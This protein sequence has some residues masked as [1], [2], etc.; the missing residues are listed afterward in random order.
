SQT[1]R[2]TIPVGSLPG[3]VA[4]DPDGQR[5]YV[6]NAD[7]ATVSIVDVLSDAV[8]ATVPVGM[9]PSALAVEPASGRVWV[10][11]ADDHTVTVFVGATPRAIALDAAGPFAYVTNFDDDSVMVI[12]TSVIG[13]AANAVV[14]TIPVPDGPLGVDVTPDGRQVWV[15]RVF[16]GSVS[17]IDTAL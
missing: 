12:D 5:L 2:A 11:N 13:T 9:N 14:A 17:V 16:D 3:A 8:I 1:V 6:A 15:A 10:A 4:L 7:S